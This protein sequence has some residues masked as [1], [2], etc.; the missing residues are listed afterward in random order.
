MR[1]TSNIKG[2][3]FNSHAVGMAIG[4]PLDFQIDFARN[5]FSGT[6]A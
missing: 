3:L 2:S 4:Q 5:P 1:R 6:A